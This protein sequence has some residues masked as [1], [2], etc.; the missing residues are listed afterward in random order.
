M[1]L[2]VKSLHFVGILLLVL[3]AGQVLAQEEGADAFLKVN[4]VDLTDKARIKGEI[5]IIVGLDVPTGALPLPARVSPAVLQRRAT[6]IATA[7]T[8]LIGRLSRSVTSHVKKFKY[9]PYVAMRV[10]EW[11]LNEILQDTEVVSVEEDR[12]LRPTLTDTPALVDAVNAWNAGHTGAGQVVAVL[13]TGVDTAHPFLSGKAV[14]EACFS[15][16]PVGYAGLCPN[17]QSSQIGAGAGVNCPNYNAG[18]YHGTHVAGIAVGKRG[19]LGAD[20]GGMAPGA[21][22]IPIQVFVEDCTGG[23]CD[24]SAFTSDLV[25]A[26]DHVHSL[27]NT[28]SIAAVNLSLGGAPTASPCDNA[29]P[30]M[31]AS[32]NSL[33][34]ANIATVI[35]TGND[36]NATQVSFPA[37]ISSAISVGSTTKQNVVSSFSNG[38]TAVELFAPGSSIYSSLPGGEYG[39]LSGTSM[40]TPHVAGAWATVRSA[41]PLAQVSDV[42]NAF[43]LTGAP[44]LDARNGLT[45]PLIQINQA[46]NA[47]GNTLPTVSLT[48]P[49]NNAVYTAP[50]SITLNATA[51]DS[52]GTISQVEFYSGATLINTDTS[53]PYSFNW[54][55]VPAGAYTLTAKA[56][57]NAG[58][59]TI[60][61][62]VTVTVNAG[63]GAD[64][65][66]VEDATPVGATLAGTGETWA[67]IS[68][69]PTP[70]SGSAAHQSAIG[71]GLHQHY[72]YGAPVANRLTVGVGEILYAYVYLDPANPPSEVMLQWNNNN[73]EHRAYWGANSIGG[74]GV[75]GTNSRRYMGPL[76]PVGQWVRLE[77]PAS[78][79]G[80]EGYALNGMAFTLYNGRATW[81][82]A[83]KSGGASN[84]AP[85]VSIT[86]PLNNAVYTAPA[87]IT[88]NATATDT[89]GTISKVEFYEGATLL[90]TDTTA[91]YSV[92]LANVGAGIYAYTAKAYDNL[93]A[94]STS[95]VVNVSV[96]GT[97]VTPT[98]TLTAPANNAVYTAPAS[99]T[100]NATA[101]DSDGT[102]SQVEF[103]SGATLINTDTSA[104]Y[105]FNWSNVP[106][107]AYTLTAKAY[108]NAG[109]STISAPVTVTV[110]AG[111]GADVIWVEDATPVGAT[112][113][114]T[115]ETWAWISANPTPFSGSAAHQS[116]IGVGLHQHYFYGA[117]VANRLTVGVGEILYAYV[118][119]DP[120][121]PP[122]EVMLQWNNNNW[123]HRAYWGANSIGGYGVNGTNSR[124]YMGPLP[125]VGQWVRLEVPASLVGLEGY[126]LNGMAFT[127]Y[128]GRATW[129]Q[130]GKR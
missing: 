11:T 13:D 118:Y 62:P 94:I 72:F 80:L 121:N 24:L 45:I 89:D 42:L 55:N 25:L 98:S 67:W 38:G 3:L 28:Y 110:N 75:N 91:P 10:N 108:D 123:E 51:T 7:Q 76:P 18:C 68:A 105:S 63:S 2:I 104:P 12:I 96:T 69:N 64:V 71:V 129:D 113:A 41:R 22:L 125:P 32:I 114:G 90:N 19:V 120:A 31:T 130:A 127:L 23:T 111:S 9:H 6:D 15:N 85:A 27:R 112:L 34:A 5:G 65:I 48:A 50:A 30:S 49:A 97:N 88:L 126:A 60:S 1:S 99:I 36:G 44:I 128:N 52:D 95:A 14:A 29:S 40:A 46:I 57:D 20:A 59:S 74:Y 37:C 87:N 54:S 82:Q 79:V 43:T 33:R 83:G 16:A 86:A 61:A 47:L 115:G 4:R 53:A 106:A 84:V 119:L 70:F 102:I 117:P 58:A 103:Y 101:T 35:A 8:R 124:R 39:N 100:L 81:D 77:V 107:G 92:S 66:W 78:L 109:A 73:W 21:S 17:G 93:G 116:A 122:S 56:Y 26:L